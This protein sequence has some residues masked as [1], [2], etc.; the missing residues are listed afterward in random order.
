MSSLHRPLPLRRVG[1]E[2]TVL[3]TAW[4]LLERSLRRAGI[5]LLRRAVAA[6]AWFVLLAPLALVALS[7]FCRPRCCIG[8]QLTAC[9][10]NLKN[11]ATALEMYASDNDGEYPLDFAPMLAGNY[12]KAVPTCPASDANHY[13]YQRRGRGLR[14]EFEMECIGTS[15]RKHYRDAAVDPTDYPRYDSAQ[16]LI[17][18]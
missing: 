14:C 18:P 17:N 15:H 5:L 2:G 3:P 1:E 8:G 10:S 16:G 6:S 9:K 7:P 13:R 11:M 12:L 4:Q